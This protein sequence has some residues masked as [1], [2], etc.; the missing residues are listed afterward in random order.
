[1]TTTIEPTTMTIEH[2]DPGLLVSHPRNVRGS[3]GDLTGLTASIRE[4][5][6]LEPLLVVPF[7]GNYVI[8][9]GHRRAAAAIEAGLQTVPCLVRAD[10]SVDSDTDADTAKE[11]A[12]MLAENLHREGLTAVEEARGIQSMLDLGV[13]IAR[14]S[15]STGLDRKRVA[16]AA[17]VARLDQGTADMVADMGLT[18]DQAAVVAMYADEPETSAKLAAAAR[19]GEGRFAHAVAQ[20]K[21]EREAQQKFDAMR[22]ELE[23]DG[24]A[25]ADDVAYNGRKN[26]RLTDLRQDGEQLTEETHA[27][28]PGRAV[29][30]SQNWNGPYAV[31]VCTDYVAHGHADRYSSSTAPAKPE[32]EEDKEAAT[33]ER[34]AVI[35]NN[36]AMAA[37]N[38]VRRAWVKELL[39]RRTAPPE[40]LRF[41]VEEIAARPQV[42]SWWLSGNSAPGDKDAAT[43]LGLDQPVR[44]WSVSAK[45]KRTTLTTGEQVPDARLPLQLLAH[46]AGAIELGIGKD[47][48]RA[49]EDRGDGL[50]RWLRF[51]T[52]LGYTLSDVEQ[53]IVDGAGK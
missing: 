19:D 21:Q 14:V 38:S 24:W 36:K 44:P 32:T 12:A 1:M 41:A 39:A 42:F 53:G 18:L 23:A 11:I 35:E 34:R 50:V 37:A 17:G 9:A 31:E 33:A 15:K 3:L 49:T 46:V 26:R 30:L 27:A 7:V 43:L 2:L 20:A 28:C 25:F 48:W 51:L 10:V 40:V 45:E 29:Y 5:G 4:Q 6:V 8:V 22:A 52:G 13:S 47:A 16:K